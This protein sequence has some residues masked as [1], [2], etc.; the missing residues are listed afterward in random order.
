MK[1][2]SKLERDL[3]NDISK[4][5]ACSESGEILLYDKSDLFI[6]DDLQLKELFERISSQP[7]F[8]WHPLK[9]SSSLHRR[10]LLELYRNIGVRLVSESVLK[11]GLL[12]QRRCGRPKHVKPADSLIGKGLVG[13]I[14]GFL[15]DP[16]L[17]MQAKERHETVECLINVTVLESVQSIDTSFSFELPAGGVLKGHASTMVR[18]DKT[19]SKFFMQK[20]D[21][22]AGQE[23]LIEYATHFAEIVAKGVL[24]QKEH[25]VAP[26]SELIKLGFLLDFNERAIQFLLKSKNLHILQ[27]DEEF[28]SASFP[29]SS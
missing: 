29:S 28:L 16:L 4:L 25:L 22:S 12:K 15:E 5:P 8:V 20:L 3:A 13:P 24:W 9:S 14:L 26:L 18:W 6:A 2:S 11:E 17:N 23:V 10:K 7:L 19:S 1:N 27:E 21:R